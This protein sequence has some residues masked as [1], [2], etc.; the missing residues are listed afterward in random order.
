MDNKC[1]YCKDIIPEGRQVC[2]NCEMEKSKSGKFR[3]NSVIISVCLMPNMAD[4][5][6]DFALERTNRL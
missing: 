3:Y 4:R 2:P 5:F 1:V 6:K